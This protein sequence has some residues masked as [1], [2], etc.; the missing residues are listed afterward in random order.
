MNDLKKAINEIDKKIKEKSREHYNELGILNAQRIDLNLQLLSKQYEEDNKK[1]KEASGCRYDKSNYYPVFITA[2][3]SNEET[4][5][6]YKK[7]FA[8]KAEKIDGRKRELGSGFCDLNGQL[9]FLWI[10]KTK[11]ARE[12]FIIYVFNTL[13]GAHFSC[14]DLS[15]VEMMGS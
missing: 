6:I 10:F 1:F 13:G 3:V 4:S 9:S 5:R 2:T 12:K 15:D 7:L 14:S 8:E 11:G